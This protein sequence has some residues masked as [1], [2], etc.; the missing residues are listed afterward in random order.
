MM[1]NVDKGLKRDPAPSIKNAQERTAIEVL[2]VR[3][4]AYVDLW[5]RLGN[6]ELLEHIRWVQSELERVRDEFDAKLSAN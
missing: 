3:S 5:T 4:Q 6:K 1:N 2:L